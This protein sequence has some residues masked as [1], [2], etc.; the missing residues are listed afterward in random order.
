MNELCPL[1]FRELG[2]RGDIE[3]SKLANDAGNL[4]FVKQVSQAFTLQPTLPLWRGTAT[5]FFA[6]AEEGVHGEV[7]A[8]ATVP[9]NIKA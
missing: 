7:K 1:S 5:L 8:L 3:N 6:S 2:L 4:H 9:L